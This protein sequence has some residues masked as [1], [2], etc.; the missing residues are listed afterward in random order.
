MD[1]N[2]IAKPLPAA[3]DGRPDADLVAGARAGEP[4]AFETVMRRNSACCSA[5]HAT[6]FLMTPRPRTW[7]RKPTCAPSPG[8]V[9]FAA[10]LR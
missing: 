4:S 1:Q 5:P 8:W 3:V 9:R 7:C 10:R 6:W 2:R